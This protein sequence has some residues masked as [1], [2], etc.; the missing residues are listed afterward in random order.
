MNFTSLI[1]N[2]YVEREIE[3]DISAFI[4]D[5]EVLVIRGPR[6]SGKSTLLRKIG[7]VLQNKHGENN[8]FY[9]DFEDELEQI[10]FESKPKEYINLFVQSNK[11]V[12]LLIDEIQYIRNSGRI[13]KLL[14]EQYPNIKFIVSGSSSLDIN[15]IGE[16]LVGRSIFFDLFPFSF[17]EFLKA[18]DLILYKEFISKRSN[19]E[20]PKIT[21]S[22]QI[23][24]INARL[25]EYLV[26]GGYP[27]IVLETNVE[28]KKMLLKNLFTT[29]IEKDVIKLYGIKYKEK[30]INLLK[31]LSATTGSLINYNDICNSFSLHFQELNV[32]L[33]IFEETFIIRKIRPFHKNLITE[34]KKNP[35]IYFYDLGMRNVL[36]DRFEFIQEEWGKLY[37]N[38]VFL[39]LKNKNVAY[40]RTNAKAEVDF[41]LKDSVLPVEV[42]I[43]P[44]ITRSL[45]SFISSYH[46]HIAII[47]NFE[48]SGV[49]KRNDTKIY[50]IPLGLLY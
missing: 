30:A 35:K 18:K 24:K 40:W 23:D 38:Y 26:Y 15:K 39:L 17:P 28:K 16:K 7:S 27:R 45:L 5:R 4:E 13:L 11:K 29:Y 42:K 14:Y 22:L 34:L 2:N 41:I 32:L 10:K 50:C 37:E 36:M 44:K 6:Q 8:V 31:Y 48:K 21:E 1:P 19:L 49:M 20:H 9:F 33:S 43:T 3:K 12:Y 25:K 46:S 47:A